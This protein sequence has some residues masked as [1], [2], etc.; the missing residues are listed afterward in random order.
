MVTVNCAVSVEVPTVTEMSCSPTVAEAGTVITLLTEPSLP[1]CTPLFGV[2]DVVSNLNTIGEL[3]AKLL[4]VT[5]ISV[6][7]A[8][9]VG[10]KV[11]SVGVAVAGVV[12]I[13]DADFIV[14][15]TVTDTVW[16]VGVA[17]EG[18]MMVAVKLPLISVTVTEEITVESKLI[19][20]G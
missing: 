2:I 19:I 6:P 13:K 3:A 15:P 5:E 14:A 18:M 11:F 10:D 8:P 17:F 12:T 4:P 20:T 7:A 9:D 16:V 1:V